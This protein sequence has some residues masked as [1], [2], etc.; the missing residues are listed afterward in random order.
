MT[1]HTS[2]ANPANETPVMA[3]RVKPKCCCGGEGA[4][5]S[6][7]ATELYGVVEDSIEPV[8]LA[9]LEVML[10][11][12]VI[13][14][15]EEVLCDAREVD[16]DVMDLLEVVE[17]KVE[18]FPGPVGLGRVFDDNEVTCEV[19]GRQDV[20]SEEGKTVNNAETEVAPALS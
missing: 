9:F 17:D 13:M 2:T 3:P 11:N 4:E 18:V 12:V 7:V 8:L 5:F 1:M 14:G 16:D 10:E 19:E 6:E 20:S 15:E